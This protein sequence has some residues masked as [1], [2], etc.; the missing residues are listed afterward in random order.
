MN[1]RWLIFAGLLLFTALVTYPVWHGLAAR[2]STAGP[3]LRKVPGQ[4]SC[5][6]PRETMRRSHMALLMAWR[7][8]KV[9]RQQ[10]QY[11]AADGQV[12]AVSLTG[13]CL[14]RCHGSKEQFCDRCHAY[15]GVPAPDCWGCH[16]SPA[17]EAGPQ[18]ASLPGGAQ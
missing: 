13:T 9:R 14:T 15:A 11:A 18:T 12:Y 5:V 7:D 8:G 2:S 10:R 1:D 17:T 16:T 4:A 3:E 6:A